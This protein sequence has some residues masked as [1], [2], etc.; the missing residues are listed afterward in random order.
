M[1]QLIQ[2]LIFNFR[3]SC[4]NK[5]S[6]S[7]PAP[8]TKQ[9]SS[10]KFDLNLNTNTVNSLLK[11]Q[12]GTDLEKLLS[13]SPKLTAST[14][15]L[16]TSTNKT[17]T[18]QQQ[19]TNLNNNNNTST[20]ANNLP[21]LIEILIKNQQKQLQPSQT[22][23]N[24]NLT[25]LIYNLFK[26]NPL[27]PVQTQPQPYLAQNAAQFQLNNLFQNPLL[28][29][30]LKVGLGEQPTSSSTPNSTPTS[31][32]S[33]T[34]IPQSHS[35]D[36]NNLQNQPMN[37]SKQNF[38]QELFSHDEA[39][40]DLSSKTKKESN[41]VS[42]IVNEKKSLKIEKNKTSSK[43]PS[44]DFGKKLNNNNNNSS[45]L[46]SPQSPS[47]MASNSS[48]QKSPSTENNQDLEDGFNE[49]E[50]IDEQ[51]NEDGSKT[52]TQSNEQQQTTIQQ[53]VQLK[54][55]G[56]DK[57]ICK[58]CFK[59]F[60]RSANLTRHLRTHT[61][62]QPYSCSY[63]ERSFSISSNLQRHIRNIHNREKPFKCRHYS[64]YFKIII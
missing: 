59:S 40:L 37:L 16:K 6:P 22:T 25:N 39:P 11:A 31:T 38:K 62:E 64:S 45:T 27:W 28:T 21:N 46:L 63:C 15:S 33:S 54:S 34:P 58:Y 29:N 61:G 5:T 41:E 2:V 19:T 50:D 51:Q 7:S 43:K 9:S 32:P 30:Y 10:Q 17:T 1:I 60:P 56:K 26:S 47:S 44:N 36:L 52:S 48:N 12:N 23:T 3:L 49:T 53:Q 20:D 8:K 18:Q 57:H 24:Q 35:S 14:D 42:K 4:K 55:G 13:Q